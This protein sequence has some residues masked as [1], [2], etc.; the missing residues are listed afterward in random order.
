MADRNDRRIL[1]LDLI[2]RVCDIKMDITRSFE[3][4]VWTEE[5]RVWVSL[6]YRLLDDVHLN[7]DLAMKEWELSKNG[8]KE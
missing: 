8:V 2:D 3:D 1:L 7:L 4:E 6:A 5:E